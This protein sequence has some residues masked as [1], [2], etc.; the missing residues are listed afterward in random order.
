[1][2][3]VINA[4]KTK[5]SDI[6]IPAGIEAIYL[7]GSIVKNKLRADSDIDVAMLPSHKIDDFGRLELISKI[8]SIFTSLFLKAGFKQE[9]S[10]LD[11]RGKY[12]SLQLL[13]NVITEGLLAFERDTVQRLEFENA[14]KREYFDFEPFLRLLRKEKHGT[15]FQKV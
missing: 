5:L 10:V 7:Y 13:Y 14:V 2:K 15:L 4:L 11:L 12:T 1:M 3:K 9:V 6:T 8:Q